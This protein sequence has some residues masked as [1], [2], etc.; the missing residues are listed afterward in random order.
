MSLKTLITLALGMLA[1]SCGSQNVAE[2]Y[3]KSQS[4]V[5]AA[6]ASPAPTT[7]AS[8]KPEA[9][10]DKQDG[11]P[12]VSPN[13]S[14][15]AKEP[16]P[17]GD[18]ARGNKLLSACSTCHIPGGLAKGVVLNASAVSRLDTAFTGQ[19]S[20]IHSVFAESF[21]APGRVDLEAA[22]SAIK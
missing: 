4:S 22:L 7:D 15:G 3:M 13:D 8:P 11:P 20:A 19:Q 12:V 9:N 14:E 18:V 21:Q 6:D 2:D 5:T 1:A 16:A 10:M 17:A